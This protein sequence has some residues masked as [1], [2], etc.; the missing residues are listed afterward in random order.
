[1]DDDD[2]VYMGS[3]ALSLTRDVIQVFCWELVE[4]KL[5]YVDLVFCCQNHK[6]DLNLTFL[7]LVCNLV[8][9]QGQK[10]KTKQQAIKG[11]LAKKLK[12]KIIKTN[13][14]IVISIK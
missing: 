2:G 7:P 10:R 8:S 9:Q 13:H 12:K 3:L 4:T 5:F 6:I 1:M 14:I 11:K